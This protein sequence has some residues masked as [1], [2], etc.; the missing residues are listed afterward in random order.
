M[1]AVFRADGSPEIGMGHIMRS[2]VLA[3][4]LK[5]GG[6]QVVFMSREDEATHKLLK[7]KSIEVHTISDESLPLHGDLMKEKETIKAVLKKI[8]PDVVVTDSYDITASYLETIKPYCKV[9]VS[10]DD[11]AEI[12][13]CSDII[14]NGNLKG[15]QMRYKTSNPDVKLLLGPRYILLGN[16]F[17]ELQGKEK[18]LDL[19]EN[20]LVTM[21]GGDVMNLT[22][23]VIRAFSG[24][25][26]NIAIRVMLGPAFNNLDEI[27]V[28]INESKRSFEILRNPKNIA[29]LMFQ[30][31][32]AVSGGGSTL[33]ELAVA[34]TPSIVLCQARNQLE[35]A[36]A[37]DKYGTVVNLGDGRKVDEEKIKNTLEYLMRAPDVVRMMK[38]RCRELVDGRGVVRVVDVIEKELEVRK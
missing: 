20:I 24:I 31:D 6:C 23:K 7:E 30:A 3:E 38:E 29:E 19:I 9:L 34:G 35:L 33:Y 36:D 16:Q 21:G 22:P 1:R 32:L 26:H 12:E 37:L 10:I 27:K 14:V 8:Q 17:R 4:E 25:S 11:L 18:S 15:E 13:F 2:V 5:R 28:A